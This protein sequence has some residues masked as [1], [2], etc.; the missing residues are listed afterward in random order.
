ML[1]KYTFWGVE[2][3]LLFVGACDR[4]KDTHPPTS[5]KC[6][7]CSVSILAIYSHYT[8]LS[9]W[10]SLSAATDL[11]PDLDCIVYFDVRISYFKVMLVRESSVGGTWYIRI[12][13]ASTNLW[14]PYKTR[15]MHNPASSQLQIW[16]QICHYKRKDWN[17][18]P[19]VWEPFAFCWG[20]VTY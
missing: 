4:T 14:H 7:A 6:V 17:P 13:H 18:K 2:R 8:Q 5:D 12:R 11:G 9:K 10:L 19:L 15:A 20:H 16:Y 3:L 1:W